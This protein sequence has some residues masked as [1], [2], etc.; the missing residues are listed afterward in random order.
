M[1]HIVEFLDEGRKKVIERKMAVRCHVC[2]A[3]LS[4]PP[5]ADF[6]AWVKSGDVLV[7][8]Q[9]HLEHGN[10]RTVGVQIEAVE[11]E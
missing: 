1:T 11:K 5:E 9:T 8:K 4:C 2:D 3:A 6:W 10:E 7:F